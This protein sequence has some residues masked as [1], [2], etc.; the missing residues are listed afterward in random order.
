M[1]PLREYLSQ[2][3]EIAHEASKDTRIRGSH[4]AWL[5]M[6]ASVIVTGTMTYC[7][8]YNGMSDNVLWRT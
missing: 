4:F 7:L 2:L 3:K 5:M 8:C 6:T 1:R